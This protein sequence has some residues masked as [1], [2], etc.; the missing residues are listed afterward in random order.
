MDAKLENAQIVF[1]DAKTRARW[2]ITPK[3]CTNSLIHP[4]LNFISTD[5]GGAI[6][7]ESKSSKV[8]N[9]PT[10]ED[11]VATYNC[12]HKRCFALSSSQSLEKNH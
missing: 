5:A 7:V 11:K 9:V 10:I 4:W 8:K 1:K 12:A 2:A 6:G 3:T